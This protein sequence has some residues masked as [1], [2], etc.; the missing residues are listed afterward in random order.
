LV[1]HDRVQQLFDRVRGVFDGVL[2][3]HNRVRQ[4]FDC[5]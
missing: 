5:V 2:L 1:K 4:L 3:K